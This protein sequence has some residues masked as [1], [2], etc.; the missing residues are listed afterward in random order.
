M[1]RFSIRDVLW[2]TVVV[3]LAIGLVISSQRQ[4]SREKRLKL[5]AFDIAASELKDNLGIVMSVNEH[6]VWLERP[7]GTTWRLCY[8]ESNEP[9]RVISGNLFSRLP[10][11]DSPSE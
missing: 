9:M 11:E 5:W 10:S 1:F 4:M 7:D 3:A 6:G 2:L 8:S